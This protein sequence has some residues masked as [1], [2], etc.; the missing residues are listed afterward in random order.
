MTVVT[1]YFNCNV[2]TDGQ[3]LPKDLWVEDGRIVDPDIIFYDL[4]KSPDV[5]IDCLG[6]LVAPGFIDLQING[7]FGVDFTHSCGEGLDIVRKGLLQYGVTGFCPTIV[8]TSESSYHKV[9]PKLK[10]CAG[11]ELGAAILGAHVEGP[12]I[13]EHKLGAHNITNTKTL[14]QTSMTD[15]YGSLENISIVT[16]APELEGSMA[17]IKMLAEKGIVVSVGHTSAD[18]YTGLKAVENGA[19]FITHLFNAML[20]FHHRDPGI[21]GLIASSPSDNRQMYFGLIADGIHTHPAALKIAHK[22][23]PKGLVLVTDAISVAGL[24]DGIHHLADKQIEL[25]NSKAYIADTNTLCGSTTSLDECLRCFI[26]ATDCSVP[27]AIE[28]V[29]LHPAQVLG[30][31]NVKGT[32]NFGADADFVLLGNNLNVLSTWIGGQCVYKN[33]KGSGFVVKKN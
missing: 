18:M 28:A 26:N 29:T 19:K 22:I 27:E 14:E 9:L 33:K 32:L 30:I 5:E 11:D 21:V 16:M 7:A 1:K 25:K 12:F 15:T 3:I 2:L 31:E 13:S 10:R 8:T 6:S 24:S 4:R 23:N 17:A 20:P